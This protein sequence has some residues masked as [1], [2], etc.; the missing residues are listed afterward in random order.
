M[1]GKYGG[2]TKLVGFEGCQMLESR[3][4]K[5]LKNFQRT[6]LKDFAPCLTSKDTPIITHTG[7]FRTLLMGKL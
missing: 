2:D 1:R 4:C 7:V 6:V 3:K 5:F